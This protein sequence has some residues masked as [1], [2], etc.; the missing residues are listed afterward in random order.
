MD[1]ACASCAGGAWW[2][3][4]D[5]AGARQEFRISYGEERKR[6]T[7]GGLMC[8][9]LDE[10]VVRVMMRRIGMGLVMAIPRG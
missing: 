6:G 2:R 5:R 9:F 8:R 1:R 10:R 3:E 4:R 7:E